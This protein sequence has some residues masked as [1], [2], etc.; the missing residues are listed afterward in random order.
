MM[1]KVN[2]CIPSGLMDWI[3][4]F[5]KERIDLDSLMLLTETD[6]GNTRPLNSRW[7]K[8]KTIPLKSINEIEYVVV[9]VN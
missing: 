3:P 7:L 9:S 4:T 6:L 5:I 2:K 1:N 8:K